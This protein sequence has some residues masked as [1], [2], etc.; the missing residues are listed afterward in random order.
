MKFNNDKKFAKLFSDYKHYT[1]IYMSMEADSVMSCAAM[2]DA[3]PHFFQDCDVTGFAYAKFNLNIFIGDARI[4]FASSLAEHLNLLEHRAIEPFM[5]M[6]VYIPLK[7]GKPY[8]DGNTY[9]E[10]VYLNFAETALTYQM[11]D[12]KNMRFVVPDISIKVKK[13]IQAEAVKLAKY[14]VSEKL[15]AVIDN[16]IIQ[17]V[18]MGLFDNIAYNVLPECKNMREFFNF[19][20]QFN[21]AQ[22]NLGY[23][24][25][26][27]RSAMGKM[28]VADILDGKE[29]KAFAA[30]VP[31]DSVEPVNDEQ[32]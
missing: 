16:E 2:A 11:F 30:S 23:F 21:D 15:G 13:T 29:D 7:D 17:L 4:G 12:K 28:S 25:A 9:H 26:K 5:R 10:R 24:V 20:N 27:M 32:E 18:N 14:L 22:L 1:A 6:P 8:F 31:I 3:Y 19:D